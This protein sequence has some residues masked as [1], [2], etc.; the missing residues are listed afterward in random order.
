MKIT[1]IGA[2]NVGGL[3]AM[4]IAHEKLGDVC[5]IDVAPGL[6]RAKAFDM[7]DCRQVLDNDY[8]L[9]GT[10]DISAVFGSHVIVVTAGL[11]RKPGMTREDLLQKNAAIVKTICAEI[12]K[13]APGA[14][15]IMVTNPLDVMTHYCLTQLAFPRERVFGMGVTLDGSRF[16]NLIAAQLNVPAS[17]IAPI[18]LGSHGEAMLPLPRLTLVGTDPLTEVIKDPAVIENL[19]KRTV[20]RGK[21]IVSLYGSG[22]AYFAPSAAIVQLVRAVA[23]D[24]KAR[25]GVSA[26]LRGEYGLSD[27]CVG[28]PCVIG[29]NGIEKIVELELL[30]QEQKA[31]RV[32]AEAIRSLQAILA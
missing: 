26:L 12:K 2:G 17:S 30:P 15:V 4:R 6:A 3:A 7:D 16:A 5:L 11:A 29:R 21:E 1:I 22:S 14:V 8:S 19:I 32:S 10:E 31:L 27:T 28:V 9:T 24:E 13:G 20:E 25:L 23:K 18:V